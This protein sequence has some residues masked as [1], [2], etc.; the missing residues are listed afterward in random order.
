MQGF[1][2]S[3]ICLAISGTAFSKVVIPE[4]THSKVDSSEIGDCWYDH[5]PHDQANTKFM[6]QTTVSG[7]TLLTENSNTPELCQAACVAAAGT[8]TTCDFWAFTEFPNNDPQCFALPTCYKDEKNHCSPS[9]ED[10]SHCASG[11]RECLADCPK[12]NYVGGLDKVHWDCSPLVNPYQNDIP[13]ATKCT[14]TCPVWKA[15]SDGSPATTVTTHCNNGVWDL[16]TPELETQV[17][18]PD[19]AENPLCS[20]APIQIDPTTFPTTDNEG[21]ELFCTKDDGTGDFELKKDPFSIQGSMSCIFMCDKHFIQEVS[22]NQGVWTNGIQDCTSFFCWSPP[23][24][25]DCQG[26]L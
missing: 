9:I 11:P 12:L 16:P 10:G 22:C 21:A 17:G 8:G 24:V 6:C 1:T 19:E 26:S 20:C 18:K 4:D 3:I 23:A 13:S 25:E 2:V 5:D 15:S 7:A 14:A